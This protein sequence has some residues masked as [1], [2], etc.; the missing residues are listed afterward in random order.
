M[1][2]FNQEPRPDPYEAMHV[3]GRS[4]R[5]WIDWLTT[6]ADGTDY[7]DFEVPCSRY[8]RTAREAAVWAVTAEVAY[9]WLC[10]YNSD[11]VSAEAVEYMMSLTVNDHPDIAML[12]RE[13]W[14]DLPD[15]LRAN[16][17]WFEEVAE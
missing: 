1:T 12:V 4:L 13:V 2:T 8:A 17:Q 6:S 16:V 10:G 11:E 15:E 3:H 7:G 14:D 5:S 9:V